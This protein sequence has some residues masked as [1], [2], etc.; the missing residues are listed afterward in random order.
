M[1]TEKAQQ[2]CLEHAG[3]DGFDAVLYTDDD[4]LLITPGI[5]ES[6]EARREV[7]IMEGF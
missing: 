3:S 1:G 4:M 5:E 2:F 7:K 6:F